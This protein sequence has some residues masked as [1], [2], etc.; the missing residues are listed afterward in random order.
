MAEPMSIW[1]LE[2]YAKDNGGYNSGRFLFVSE[3]G[4]F[5]MQ[6]LDACYGFVQILQPELKEKGFLTTKQLREFFGD[7]QKY[8]PTIGYDTEE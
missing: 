1:Q 8:L 7:D 4:F 3:K 6:W 2:E 5:E